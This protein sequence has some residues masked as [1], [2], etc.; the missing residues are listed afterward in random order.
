MCC[1]VPTGIFLLLFLTIQSY[2]S[3]L[4]KVL[5]DKNKLLTIHFDEVLKYSI[6]FIPW[7]YSVAPSLIIGSY[8]QP[9]SPSDQRLIDLNCS[10]ITSLSSLCFNP[11]QPIDIQRPSVANH[12]CIPGRKISFSTDRDTEAI[13]Y[14]FIVCTTVTISR[15]TQQVVHNMIVG[16]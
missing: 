4:L 9:Y 12:P 5:K 2:I 1:V 3:I 6:R 15:S 7:V 14:P 10:E 16:S 8:L 13:S 11:S